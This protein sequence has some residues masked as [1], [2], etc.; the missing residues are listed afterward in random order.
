VS[1]GRVGRYSEL[2]REVFSGKEGSDKPVKPRRTKSARAIQDSSVEGGSHAREVKSGLALP[3]MPAAGAVWNHDPAMF[4]DASAAPK[5][6][7]P[8]IVSKK[9]SFKKSEAAAPVQDAEARFNR[10]REKA[11]AVK[12][13][14]APS[15]ED[16]RR[17][18]DAMDERDDGT[19]ER[20][21]SRHR[22]S[23]PPRHGAATMFDDDAVPWDHEREDD[24]GN[25]GV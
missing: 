22:N 6:A 15:V 25:W 4:D 1:F 11:T 13:S 16:G 23:A 10:I 7:E 9:R 5:S 19:L 18:G 20:R 21:V 12:A 2:V 3:I 17:S 8:G 14:G 24:G